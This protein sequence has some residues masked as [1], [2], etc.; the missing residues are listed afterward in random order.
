MCVKRKE[1]AFVLEPPAMSCDRTVPVDF[2]R[3]FEDLASLFWIFS[4]KPSCS[5]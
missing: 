2:L 3:F 1:V 4:K 5:G